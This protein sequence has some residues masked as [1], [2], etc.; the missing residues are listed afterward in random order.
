MN[1]SLFIELYCDEDVDVL[2]ADLMRARGFRAITTQEVNQKA[3]TDEEQLAY[4]G[5]E[6]LTLLTHNRID[7]ENLAQQYLSD[8]KTHFGIIIASQRDPYEIARRLFVLL[9]QV[10]AD[11]M[12]NQIRYI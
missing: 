7:F 10:T 4:A 9:N 1:S 3:Q 5:S 6:Q 12:V 11:E 8:G 2:V